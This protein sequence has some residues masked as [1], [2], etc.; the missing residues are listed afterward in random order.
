MAGGTEDIVT[1]PDQH[2][3]GPKKAAYIGAFASVVILLLMLLGNHHGR[4]EDL[5]LVV[6]AALLLVVL[7]ADWALRKNGIK[8]SE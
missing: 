5:W 8:R 6:V 3:P 2:K 4:I 7:L 1:S